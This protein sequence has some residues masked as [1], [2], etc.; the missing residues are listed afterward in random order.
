MDMLGGMLKIKSVNNR[1]ANAN[2]C[3]KNNNNGVN[4]QV[5]VDHASINT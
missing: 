1:H 2:K 3:A 5:L 4:R